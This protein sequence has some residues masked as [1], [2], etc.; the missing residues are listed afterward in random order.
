[1]ESY[2][3]LRRAGSDASTV[4]LQK[5]FGAVLDT[6]SAVGILAQGVGLP[7]VCDGVVPLHRRALLGAD[8][9]IVKVTTRLRTET[10]VKV[11]TKRGTKQTKVQTIL[12]ISVESSLPQLVSWSCNAVRYCFTEAGTPEAEINNVSLLD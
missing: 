6:S 8:P 9:V 4:I 12:K 7:G 11:S 3:F 10:H 5:V 1:M 2:L